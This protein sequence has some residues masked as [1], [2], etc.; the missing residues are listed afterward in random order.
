MP[1]LPP[2]QPP[3]WQ[4]ARSV[5][6]RRANLDAFRVYAML[7]IILG[8]SEL[9]L[10]KTAVGEIQA[11]QL[12]LNIVS[13]AAVPLFLILAG[14]HLSPRLARDRV[15]GAAWPYVRRL[16]ALYAFGCAFYWLTDFLK[17]VNSRGFGPGLQGF[18]ER[19][20]ANPAALLMH[21]PRGHLWFLTVLMLVVV[22][23][24]VIL[25]YVRVRWFVLGS[26]ALYGVALAIGPYG[27][28]VQLAGNGWWY[29][30]LLQAPL[31]FSLGLVL[32]L[33]RRARA[34]ATAA[35]G[36]IAV[37]LVVHALEVQ[38]ISQTYGTWPFRL[39]MLVGTVLYAAGVAMFALSPG[40][41][42][43]SRWVGRFAPYVPAAYLIH[44]FFL[45][46]L[47]P[48]RGAFPE[49]IVRVVL[50]VIT[51]ILAFGSG[52]LAYRLQLH[53]RRR[54]RHAEAPAAA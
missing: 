36:L 33:E 49:T 11:L 18:I 24:A 31:F 32:G 10:G 12:L 25:P 35:V 37:G 9:Q 41:N 27:G 40:A 47:R 34:R 2:S 3:S 42:R 52:W 8:H 29:E 45:E 13:R 6:L 26:A 5:G 22:A 14:E 53:L 15:R 17:L 39:G 43:F 21:G 46:T 51:T 48:P 44:L 50:P 30:F 38:W 4:G 19:Q 23:A 16:A 54:R 20:A 28:P 1:S 7:V